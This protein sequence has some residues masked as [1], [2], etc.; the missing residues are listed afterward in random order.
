MFLISAIAATL[1]IQTADGADPAATEAKIQAAKE[2]YRSCIVTQAAQLYRGKDDKRLEQKISDSCNGAFDGW[3]DAMSSDDFPEARTAARDA[4]Q[5][6]L[7]IAIHLAVLA[8]AESRRA[9]R[10][11][12][13]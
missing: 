12:P 1:L 9:S 8:E 6:Q 4:M 13:S 2:T 11:T 5:P 7:R 10:V 3:L